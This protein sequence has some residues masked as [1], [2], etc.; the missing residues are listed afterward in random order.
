MNFQDAPAPKD[1]EFVS[2]DQFMFELDKSVTRMTRSR[3]SSVSLSS[4]PM[5][6]PST[7]ARR[8][9]MLPAVKDSSPSPREQGTP[10]RHGRTSA[11]G[12]KS[13]MA[14]SPTKK[15]SKSTKNILTEE[16]ILSKLNT[17]P[18]L[19][20]NVKETKTTKKVIS[21]KVVKPSAKS[22]IPIQVS[23]LSVQIDCEKVSESVRRS[24]KSKGREETGEG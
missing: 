5:A 18:I 20:S 7:K 6:K 10:G 2:A 8:Q 14:E 24:G 4:A 23:S 22:K 11:R 17:S 19:N 16:D 15:F 1:D 9:T 3:R 13:V 21:S 12:A